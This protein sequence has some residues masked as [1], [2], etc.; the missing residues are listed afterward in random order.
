MIKQPLVAPAEVKMKKKEKKM[1]AK[2]A[3]ASY[4]GNQAEPFVNPITAQMLF[5]SKQFTETTKSSS[6]RSKLSKQLN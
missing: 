6:Q 5:S 4:N 3:D 2:I 1:F